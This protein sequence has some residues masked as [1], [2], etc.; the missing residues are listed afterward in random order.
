MIIVV[1]SKA[2][3]AKNEVWNEHVPVDMIANIILVAN[4]TGDGKSIGYLFSAVSPP[5]TPLP[6]SEIGRAHV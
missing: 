6:F 2:T 1:K 5:C 4:N 3:D